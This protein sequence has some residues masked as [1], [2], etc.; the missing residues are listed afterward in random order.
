MGVLEG[1]GKEDEDELGEL[2]GWRA[3]PRL[4]GEEEKGFVG[5][6]DGSRGGRRGMSWGEE[7]AKGGY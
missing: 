2:W 5:T 6:E 4:M 7:M 3:R 1:G